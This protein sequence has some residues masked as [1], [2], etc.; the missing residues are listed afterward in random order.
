MGQGGRVGKKE[1]GKGIRNLIEVHRLIIL[2]KRGLYMSGYMY[3][4]GCHMHVPC[5]RQL[6]LLSW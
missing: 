5:L 4:H 2:V 6:L 3:M 1:E